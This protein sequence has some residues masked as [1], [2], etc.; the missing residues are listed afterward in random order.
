MAGQLY[1]P[2]LFVYHADAPKGSVQRETSKV[3]EC[4]LLRSVINPAIILVWML[5][6]CSPGRAMGG[7]PGQ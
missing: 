6:L 3:M 7:I 5:V 2:R 4:L 1:L